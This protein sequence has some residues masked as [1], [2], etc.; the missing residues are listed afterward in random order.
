[1]EYTENYQLPQWVESD[2]ILMEDFNQAMAAIDEGI[3]AV[4]DTVTQGLAEVAANLGSGGKTARIA[5]GTYV[6]TGTYGPGNPTSL[7]FAFQPDLVL[8]GSV[9]GSFSICHMIR[10]LT[11]SLSTGTSS[12]L[13]VVWEAQKV[14][15]YNDGTVINAHIGQNN[16]ENE[17]YYYVAIGHCA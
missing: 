5:W 17:T 2:R 3:K 9:Y 13:T 11:S 7:S 4:D 12:P 16:V 10:P 1:M 14:T 6:G 15:W 8:I